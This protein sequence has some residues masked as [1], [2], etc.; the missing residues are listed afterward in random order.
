MG[1]ELSHWVYDYIDKILFTYMFKYNSS[2]ILLYSIIIII[3]DYFY[4][5]YC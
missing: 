2:Q 5:N 1:K 3:I 4:K